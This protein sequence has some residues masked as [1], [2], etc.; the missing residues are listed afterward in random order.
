MR[1][2]NRN[3]AAAKFSRM[4]MIPADCRCRFDNPINHDARLEKLVRDNET[5]VPSTD[6]KHA[7]TGFHPVD[8]HQCLNRA[9]TVDTREVIPREQ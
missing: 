7:F 8:I 4:N 2:M 9:R 1:G 5:D 3:P 6:H